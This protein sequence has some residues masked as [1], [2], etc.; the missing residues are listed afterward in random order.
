MGKKK[1][2]KQTN[3]DWKRMQIYGNKNSRRSKLKDVTMEGNKKMTNKEENSRLQDR[4]RFQNIKW[5]ANK[6]STASKLK[7]CNKG[8]ETEIRRW[9]F[10]LTRTDVGIWD[11]ESLMAYCLYTKSSLDLQSLQT[12]NIWYGNSLQTSVS[13]KP[14]SH[15]T[16]RQT[17]ERTNLFKLC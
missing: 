12:K 1:K 5:A 4:C 2:K 13:S 14:A 10:E 15:D 6:D 16:N 11:S 17:F 8:K 9:I 7:T 3:N